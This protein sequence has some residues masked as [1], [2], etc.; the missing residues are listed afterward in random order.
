MTAYTCIFQGG[1]QFDLGLPKLMQCQ[2]GLWDAQLDV[3]AQGDYGVLV[4]YEPGSYLAPFYAAAIKAGT[5]LKP[6]AYANTRRK[7]IAADES[8]HV[9]EANRLY[10]DAR[11]RLPTRRIVAYT[12]WPLTVNPQYGA[13]QSAYLADNRRAAR[14]GVVDGADAMAISLYL[15]EGWFGN[16]PI[17]GA[18]TFAAGKLLAGSVYEKPKV[19]F[20]SLHHVDG[21]RGWASDDANRAIYE[22][23][24][25]DGC[26]VCFW[27]DMVSE[28]DVDE[29]KR[30]I[31][32]I[33]AK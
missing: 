19:A 5:P 15:R 30:R 1:H 16:D 22:T 23:A 10:C 4:D 27:D 20:L 21:D 18:K 17:G 6:R 32:R 2:P 25:A 3:A 14:A 8:E 33:V 7:D 26:D 31:E 12:I 28:R 13:D 9:A 11:E 24:V 29:A